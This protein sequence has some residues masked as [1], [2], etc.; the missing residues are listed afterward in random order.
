MPGGRA[1]HPPAPHGTHSK[2]QHS[3]NIFLND[4]PDAFINLKMQ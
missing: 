2:K 1:Q 3:K 4:L